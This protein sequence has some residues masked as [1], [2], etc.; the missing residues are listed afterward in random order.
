MKLYE[1]KA[2]LE[3]NRDRQFLLALP[4]ESQVPVSFHITEVGQVTK[5][6]IDCGGKAHSLQTCQLQ[7]WVGEDEDHRLNAGKISDIL[8]LAKKIVP[9]DDI[10]VEVEY[11]DAV[12]SQYPVDRAEITDESVTLH[13][14]TKHTDCL[15]KELCLVPSASSCGPTGCC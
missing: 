5:N 13:L 2:L 12:I 9:S 8:G 11:E 4:N 15:A 1:L 7:A 3:A 14:T 10:D 6:F